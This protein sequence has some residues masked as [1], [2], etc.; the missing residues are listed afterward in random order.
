MPRHS[1]KASGVGM[2]DERCRYSRWSLIPGFLSA[3]CGMHVF[4]RISSNAWH[5]EHVACC[6]TAA[7]KT[8]SPF[9]MT[10]LC[11][12]QSNGH[13]TWDS[14]PV[15]PLTCAPH[16]ILHIISQLE[17]VRYGVRGMCVICAS[18]IGYI[19]FDVLYDR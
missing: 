19:I 4:Y 12:R 16:S 17:H 15:L 8:R 13:V 3:A 18:D 9:H 10:R 6:M 2:R 7:C 1:I 11:F 14:R 5:I